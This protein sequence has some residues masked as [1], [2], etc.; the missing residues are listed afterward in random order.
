MKS[1]AII[2][3]YNRMRHIYSP[4]HSPQLESAVKTAIL[5]SSAVVTSVV[6]LRKYLLRA[7]QYDNS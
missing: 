3:S 2:P 6:T 5:Q 7:N 4:Q 1:R